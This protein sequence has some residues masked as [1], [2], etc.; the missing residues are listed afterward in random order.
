MNRK[1][2]W[3]ISVATSAEA[4][5]AFTELLARLSGQPA[6]SYTDIDTGAVNVSVYCPG[7]F[8][9]SLAKRAELRARLRQ[10][11]ACGLNVA[12]AKISVKKLRLQDWAESWKR[13]FQPIEIGDALLVKPSWS[14]RRPRRGQAIVVLDPGLSFGTGQHPTTAFCLRQL[15][16]RR[17][18]RPGTI[19]FGYWH[20][21]GN[22]R[23]CGGETR[24][25]AGSCV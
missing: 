13:H 17:R 14:N 19:L 18:T 25:R 20:R 8:A 4:E 6:C 10:V 7:G 24:I 22:S 15:A 21:F 3:K 11:S 5:E 16:A 9:R 23:H 2:L 1:A 12:P